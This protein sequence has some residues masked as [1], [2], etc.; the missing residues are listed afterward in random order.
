M[1]IEIKAL[2]KFLGPEKGEQVG[3]LEYHV[4]SNN[5]IQV[6][7]CCQETAVGWTCGTGVGNEMHTQSW[8]VNLLQSGRFKDPDGRILLKWILSN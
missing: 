8:W 3:T 4:N 2:R 5:C 6:A 1:F 7:E